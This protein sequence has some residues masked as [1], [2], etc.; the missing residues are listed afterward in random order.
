[1]ILQ[2]DGRIMPLTVRSA[3]SAACAPTQV[4][5]RTRPTVRAGSGRDSRDRDNW[6]KHAEV[7]VEHGCRVAGVRNCDKSCRSAESPIADFGQPC[8]MSC[9]GDKGHVK[10]RL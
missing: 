5:S 6:R 8:P 10:C 3:L 2:A 4:E 1:M 9:E 7:M